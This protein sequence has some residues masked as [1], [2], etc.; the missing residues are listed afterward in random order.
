M[1]PIHWWKVDDCALWKQANIYATLDIFARENSRV[2]DISGRR[3]RSVRYRCVR[4][5]AH[6]VRWIFNWPCLCGTTSCRSTSPTGQKIATDKRTSVR[7][8]PHDTRWACNARRSN[9]QNRWPL[10]VKMWYAFCIDSFIFCTKRSS[11]CKAVV[12]QV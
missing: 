7:S 9:C 6:F 12:L 3:D 5:L 10:I 8:W 1:M 11:Q 2:D 4:D